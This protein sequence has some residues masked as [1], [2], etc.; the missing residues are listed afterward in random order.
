MKAPTKSAIP[1]KTFKIVLKKFNPCLIPSAC[2]AAA[3]CALITSKFPSPKPSI[4]PL[5]VSISALFSITI[6]IKSTPPSESSN[7]WAVLN[8]NKANVA[9][10]GEPT[11]ANSAIP[12][13]VNEAGV[14]PANT[15]TLSPTEYPLFSAVVTSITTSLLFTGGFPSTNSHCFA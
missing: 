5:T 7:L 4:K 9:P 12:T 3:S 2:S 10:P 13:I 6:F 15:V 8:S 11:F 14:E 1:A